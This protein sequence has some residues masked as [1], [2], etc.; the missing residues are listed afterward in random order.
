MFV[1]WVKQSDT[2]AAD[3]GLDL[4]RCN[5]SVGDLNLHIYDTERH[6]IRYKLFRGMI[7]KVVK[8]QIG[9]MISD[10]LRKLIDPQA[11]TNTSDMKKDVANASENTT[12][13]MPTGT[14]ST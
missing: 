1:P 10:N 8:K 5:V 12:I 14:S 7:E 11:K 13:S 6:H 3:K 4:E 9:I 2:G